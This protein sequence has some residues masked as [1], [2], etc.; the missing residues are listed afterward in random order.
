[1]P[2]RAND[3]PFFPLPKEDK[4]PPKPPTKV[5]DSLFPTINDYIS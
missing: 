4:M 3:I 1:M 5:N 2:L